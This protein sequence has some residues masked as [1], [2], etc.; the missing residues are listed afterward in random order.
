MSDA[1][2]TIFSIELSGSTQVLQGFDPTR[3]DQLNLGEISV[4][5][6][7]LGQLAD[8][9]AIITSPWNENDCIVLEGVRWSELSAANFAPVGNE[10]LRQD[11]GGV[12]SWEQ[13]LGPRDPNTVYVRSHQN[14]VHERVENFDPQSQ[15]LSFLYFGSRERLSVQDTSEGLLISSEPSG[16]SLLLVGV[17]RTDLVAANL[18]FHH[19]QVMEDNLEEPFGFHQD[20][21]SL[22][23]RTE[24]FTPPAPIGASTDGE[25]VRTGE[26][27][28]ASEQVVTTTLDHTAHD[29]GGEAMDHPGA[30]LAL[31]LSGSLYWGG[32]GGTITITNTGSTAVEDWSVSFLTRQQQFQ[33]WAG[34]AVVTELEPGLFQVTLSPASW[35]RSI[36]AGASLAVD[37]NATS[38]GLPNSGELTAEQFFAAA[39][40]VMGADP[41]VATEPTPELQPNPE[42]EPASPSEPIAAADVPALSVQVELG[43]HW[44]GTYA[45]TLLITNTT[46]TDLPPGWSTSFISDDP[47]S[48][49]SN[50]SFEQQQ[51][52]DGRYL[53]TV[54]AASWAADQPLRSGASLSSYF[55]AAGEL[56]GRTAQDLFEAEAL[57][58]SESQPVA[59]IE[60]E[61]AMAIE[62]EPGAEP[63][64]APVLESPAAPEPTTAEASEAEP[65]VSEAEPVELDSTAP[66]SAELD[67]SDAMPSQ[68]SAADASAMRVVGYF[69]EWGIYS[70]DFR[71]A[72]VNVENLTHLNYSFFDVNAAGELS[73]FDSF[74][75]TEKRFSADQQV[76]RTFTSDEWQALSE[77][78]R[79]SYTGSADFMVMSLADGSISVS[80][81]PQD[82]NTPGALAGNLRQ[83]DLLKQ[84]NPDLQLGLALG[85]WTLSD[86]F[87]LAVATEQGREAFT[88]SI[89]STLQTYD[90]FNV[91]DLDWEYP[92]GG[93]EAG[94]AVSP[95]DGVN[96]AAALALL[97]QK[98]DGLEL[99]TGEDYEISVATAGGYDKLANLNLE[100]INP[101]VDFY[102]V[103]AYDFHGGW[104]ASTGHQAAMTADPGGYDVL[105]AIAQFDAA[106]VERSKVVL[107]APA[108][109][110]AWGGVSAGESFGYGNA[111][112]AR[113][114]PGSFEPGNYDSQ[115]I[116]TGVA[117]G[118][119]QLIWDDTSKAAFAYNADALIWSSIETAG[120]IAGKAS[121]VQ[122]AGLG[123]MMFWALSNDAEGDQS[124]VAAASDV[125]RGGVAAEQVVAR[126]PQFDAVLGGDG[127]FALEDFTGLA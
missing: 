14:G 31:D 64:S 32:M 24:L 20:T 84:L 41:L 122:E 93:G 115:D 109:T 73:V 118:E 44:S 69:E 23:S 28:L 89:I 67:P 81:I 74:A 58:L 52:D 95:L 107:G 99:V 12:L 121:Y 101:S 21:V 26:Q 78:R 29:H 113:Q 86:E 40:A 4:H 34:E 63:E 54:Q 127:T 68:P 33:S 25:Q 98:L 125:L 3:G 97:R 85:G 82:W 39:P 22:V 51:R 37:F 6:L 8:G 36:A 124:L 55:Q 61:T 111:G 117:G 65:V 123:G 2:A 42:P 83:L 77:E 88:D 119:Y 15:K 5:G 108:Y 48:Q 91:V 60:T 50:F 104:E 105:T 94:N 35:N 45:G 75:A 66:G 102:N 80:G 112:D 46:A 11:L 114:A 56:D 30:G 1:L 9:T 71:V 106:G 59:A 57:V 96:F 126:A 10:H 62:P 19:D 70:R 43:D 90:F 38:V 116:L 16:Q 17:K 18:E 72:D 47:L 87:S 79:S 92:G 49:L 13:G 120:T 27:V 103:M 100:G 53:I 110:R 7:I 76:S